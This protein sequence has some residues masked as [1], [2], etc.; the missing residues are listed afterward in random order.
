MIVF[1]NSSPKPVIMREHDHDRTVSTT[2]FMEKVLHISKNMNLSIEERHHRV[3]FLLKEEEEQNQ[4]LFNDRKEQ[5]QEIR[6]IFQ[7]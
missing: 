1:N 2:S 3:N 7:V 5:I 4:R 6:H